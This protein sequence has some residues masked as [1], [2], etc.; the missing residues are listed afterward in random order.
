MG[1]RYL[2][3][4]LAGVDDYS[5]LNAQR[6]SPSRAQRRSGRVPLRVRVTVS[7]P[8]NQHFD[9][10]TVTVSRYGAKLRIGHDNRNL[11]TGDHVRISQR[12]SYSWRTARISWLDRIG[13]GFCGVEL[14]D[15]EN[16]WGIY[17]PQKPSESDP[18][19]AVGY[20]PL[21]IRRAV[22]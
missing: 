1:H 17:F 7:L 5:M 14:Q 18:D 16:F 2:V 10:E 13:G 6:T 20:T 22:S 4:I 9:A 3:D 19:E 8:S 12:G 11:V 15:P 21:A